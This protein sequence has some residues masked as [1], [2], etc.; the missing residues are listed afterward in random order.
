MCSLGNSW[1]PWQERMK[2]VCYELWG[3]LEGAP[4]VRSSFFLPWYDG[5]PIAAVPD[6]ILYLIYDHLALPLS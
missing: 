6:A 3:A 4:C 1:H 2:R 5:Q